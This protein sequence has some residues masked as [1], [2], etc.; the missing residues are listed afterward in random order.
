ML[1][2]FMIVNAQ[3][4]ES[5]KNEMIKTGE[6]QIRP[7]NQNSF[8]DYSEFLKAKAWKSRPSAN[9]LFTNV[10]DLDIPNIGG[11]VRAILV[12]EDNDIALVAP[13]GGG[14]WEFNSEDGSSFKPI[15]DFGSFMAITDIVQDPNNPSHIIIATGDGLHGTVGNGLFESFDKGQSFTQMAGTSAETDSDFRYIRF[16][17]F[18]PSEQN[19]LY[20]AAGKKVFK[21]T[22]DG[23]TWTEVFEGPSSIRSLEFLSGNGVIVAIYRNGLYSSNSGNANSF[24]K[25]TSGLPS[26]TDGVVVASYAGNR[27]IVYAFFTGEDKNDIYKTTNGGSSWTKQ[28]AVSFYTAQTWF[29]I[30]LGVHPTNPD[31]LV[32]GSVGWGFS[33]DGGETWE[34]G[35]DMEVD[36]HTAHFHPSNPDVAYVGYDQG[37][38][39]VD[40]STDEL[41]WSWNGSEWVQIP[42]PKQVELGKVGGFN[43]TQV[44][45]GDYLPVSYGDSY[46]EG[47]QDGGCFALINGA[48]RRVLVGDGGSIFTHKQDANKAMAC[49][50]YGNLRTSDDATNL[51]TSTYS[52]VGEVR[53]DHPN[54]ITQFAGNNADSDQIYVASSSAIKR[55][56][57]FGTSFNSMA[58]HDLDGVKVATENVL[59]PTV[60]AIGYDRSAN[61][62]TKLLVMEKAKSTTGVDSEIEVMNYNTDGTP[63][64]IN[65]D[66][67]LSNTIYISGSRGTAYKVSGI[68]QSPVITS[69]KGDIPDVFFNT[70][71]GLEGES[72]LLLAGTNIGLFTSEDAGDTWTLSN[73]FPYTQVTDIKY[74]KEDKRLFV[75]TYGRGAWAGTLDRGGLVGLNGDEFVS[76]VSFFPN[77]VKNKLHVNVKDQKSIKT[78]VYNSLGKAVAQGTEDIVVSHLKDGHYILHAISEGELILVEPISIVK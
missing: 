6:K 65:V 36:F 7:E 53:D 77:P 15:N 1:L 35:E 76:Q 60:Y 63:D 64:H 73:D 22:D 57:N 56:A 31:I 26:T 3:K 44:Y 50:Q 16:V 20:M 25:L 54:F 58:S 46:I 45:Y 12:D 18:S 28:G 67:N 43:T 38:G 71:V 40:F 30:M 59:D 11:R 27:N 72:D 4:K 68:D 42:Q 23:D 62:D 61:W 74:R 39:S 41:V 10:K 47:Q 55:S 2:S 52:E 29:C 8:N 14:L 66:P 32:A 24:S 21:S 37:F 5:F 13:S 78:V 75:F 48:F 33:E 70:V 19:T 34:D 17:K 69:I 51:T 9:S 49:T